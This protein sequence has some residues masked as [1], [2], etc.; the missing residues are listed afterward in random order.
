MCAII[1]ITIV[2]TI[3][4]ITYLAT[5]PSRK[6]KAEFGDLRKAT[7]VEF[8]FALGSYIYHNEFT[9]SYIYNGLT[10]Y[11][12]LL[13]HGHADMKQENVIEID[14]EKPVFHYARTKL[15]V[16]GECID[17]ENIKFKIS[18]EKPVGQIIRGSHL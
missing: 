9:L 17:N 7:S 16:L 10:T 13:S 2:V 15:E 3:A 1:V 5:A 8:E 12:F 4:L 6:S 11:K 14:K 18:S